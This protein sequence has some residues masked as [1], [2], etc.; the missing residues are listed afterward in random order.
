MKNSLQY[1]DLEKVDFSFLKG[2]LISLGAVFEPCIHPR[3]NELIDILNKLECKLILVTNGHNLHR[4]GIPALFDSNLEMV[5]FSFDGISKETYEL[6][7]VG[8]NYERTLDNIEN[9][10]NAFKTSNTLFAVNFTVL[11]CNMNE[12]SGA[13]EFW[14]QRNMDVLRFISMM[15]REDDDFLQKN[16]LWNVR[17][18]YF[19]RLDEAALHARK[20]ES[21]ICIA[22]PYFQSAW[23]IENGFVHSRNT[24]VKLPMLYPRE[25]Q[26]GADFG[27]TFNCKSPFVAA[28]ILWDGT[29]MLCHNQAVG[30]LYKKKFEDIWNDDKA[31]NLRKQVLNSNTLC[32]QCD[33]FRLCLNSHFIDLE[34]PENY[35]SQSMLDRFETIMKPQLSE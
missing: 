33:Y 16:S 10:R 2:S 30:N 24:G 7:R 9:F 3:I 6:V 26:Y 5:T 32:S 20:D 23:G 4:K 1:L 11:K 8:G 13:P 18:E 12:V 35:F 28:R 21:K 19:K 17:H 15:I 29:V 34:K 14:E 25:Y 27:M 22:S 31:T